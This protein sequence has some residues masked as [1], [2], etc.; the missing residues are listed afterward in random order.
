MTDRE[1]PDRPWVGIG[2]VAFRG[3]EVLLVRRLRP[4]R[5]GEWTIPGGAQMLGEP[6]EEAA[7]REL[8]EETGVEV[9]PL[10]L[11]ACVDIV[12]RDEAGAI[13][14]HYTIVDYAGRWISGEPRAGDDASEARF[15]MPE[16]LPGL[17]LWEETLRV[18]AEGRRR[19]HES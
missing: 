6:A 4:P 15:F 11:V 2:C 18:I 14:F 17:G 3:D 16:E 7:R 8:R 19:I 1:Y 9:G 5:L 13:R 10:T 12:H